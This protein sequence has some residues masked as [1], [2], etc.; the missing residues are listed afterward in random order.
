MPFPSYLSAFRPPTHHNVYRRVMQDEKIDFSLSP[1]IRIDH[2]A[3]NAA[4]LFLPATS[5]FSSS[6]DVGS[7]AGPWGG[8]P[9]KLKFHGDPGTETRLQRQFKTIADGPEDRV[10]KGLA[11]LKAI[12]DAIFPAFD[13]GVTA[14]TIMARAAAMEV[15]VAIAN[16][17]TLS[18]GT[19]AA[20]EAV[21]GEENRLRCK[22]GSP[23]EWGIEIHTERK[24]RISLCESAA[25][26]RYHV[27]GNAGAEGKRLGK[28]RATTGDAATTGDDDKAKPAMVRSPFLNVESQDGK[29]LII[30][31]CTTFAVKSGEWWLT[32]K[33]LPHRPQRATVAAKIRPIYVQ[34]PERRMHSALS[35]EDGGVRHSAW[36]WLAF[37]CRWMRGIG[38][39]RVDKGEYKYKLLPAEAIRRKVPPP[40]YRSDPDPLDS[41][42]A[43]AERG[44]TYR[45]RAELV[46][47][48]ARTVGRR[49]GTWSGESRY[50]GKVDLIVRFAHGKPAEPANQTVDMVDVTAARRAVY[51]AL[52]G[53]DVAA[54]PGASPVPT[55]SSPPEPT[56][57]FSATDEPI[58]MG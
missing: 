45:K 15:A 42:I 19:R 41:A 9:V 40:L 38:T 22:L 58:T 47:D 26:D 16:R 28:S 53:A 14:K 21:N 48:D 11:V 50:Q 35:Y 43:L 37:L 3:Q 18:I 8:G 17:N 25:W 1:S 4:A 7:G 57:R 56:P 6:S 36:N 20:L 52:A 5:L 29:V 49:S 33:L 39:A 44:N 30:N 10:D 31:A 2:V 34:S 54:K 24:G 51:H 46:D 23:S 27:V 55:G 13:T 32:R 12:A